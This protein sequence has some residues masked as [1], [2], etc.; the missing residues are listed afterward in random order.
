M[1]VG[2]FA[3]VTG[4]IAEVV[5]MVFRV[6]VPPSLHVSNDMHFYHVANLPLL[7]LY[8]SIQL[9]RIGLSGMAMIW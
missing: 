8:H 6:I 9:Q 2:I 7:Y 3:F 1:L 4:L 5:P